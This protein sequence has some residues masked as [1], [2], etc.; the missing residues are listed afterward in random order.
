MEN[1]G[2]KRMN[3]SI[4]C[5]GGNKMVIVVGIAVTISNLT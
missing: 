5:G 1:K 4:F 3:S 2:W